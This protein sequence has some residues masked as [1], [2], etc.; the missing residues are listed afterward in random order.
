MTEEK[1][2]AIMSKFANDVPDGDNLVL[3]EALRDAPDSAYVVLIGVQT[4]SPLVTL[5]LSVFLGGLGVDRFY[6]GDVGLGIAKL[7]LGWLTLYIWPFVD[8]FLCY[9][10]AKQKN[11]RNL[12]SAIGINV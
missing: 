10:K 5:I 7:L 2:A 11:L 1:V 9:Q 12:L 4:K 6:I 8:I 3:A